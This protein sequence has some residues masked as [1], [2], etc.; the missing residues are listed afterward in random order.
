MGAMVGC[1]IVKTDERRQRLRFVFVRAP[2][3]RWE[4]LAE[5]SLAVAGIVW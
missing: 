5:F 2:L 3:A 4:G 1:D